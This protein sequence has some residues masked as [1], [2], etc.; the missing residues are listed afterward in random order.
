MTNNLQLINSALTD[1]VSF[2]HFLEEYQLILVSLIG[3]ILL[4]TTSVIYLIRQTKNQIIQHLANLENTPNNHFTPSVSYPN[5]QT[6]IEIPPR[7][8]LNAPN[9]QSGS[10]QALIAS[11]PR[12]PATEP[13]TGVK[14]NSYLSRF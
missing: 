6:H 3:L 7:A 5:E 9:V 10:P 12:Q 2:T 11:A 8:Y 1:L 14:R 4:L 13:K